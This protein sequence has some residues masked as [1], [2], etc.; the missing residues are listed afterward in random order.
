ME[1]TELRARIDEID[2][3]LIELLEQRM[4][5]AAGVAD[6]KI[7]HG[8]PVLDASREKEKYAA[9]RAKCRPET[10]D[11]IESIFAA[12]L[13]ASRAYQQAR[14]EASHAE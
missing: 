11:G 4:D 3:A 6:Y 2:A 1:L 10:A 12:A 5:V 8:L 7:A 13:A 9:I 14:M